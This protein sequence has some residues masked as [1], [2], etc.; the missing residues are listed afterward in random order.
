MRRRLLGA[1]ILCLLVL[2]LAAG[3]AAGE[4]RGE[5]ENLLV[6]PSFEEIGTNGLPVGWSVDCWIYDTGVTYQEVVEEGTDGGNCV[7]IENVVSNDARFVQ[8]VAVEPGT[9]YL[10]YGRVKA[11]GCDAERIGANLS[12]TDSYTEFPYLLDTGGEWRELACYFRTDENRR[13]VTV[14]ARLGGYSSDTTGCAWFDDLSLTRIEEGEIP[15]GAVLLQLTPFTVAPAAEEIDPVD[16]FTG[17]GTGTV[18]LCAVLAAVILYLGFSRTRPEQRRIR[19]AVILLAAGLMRVLLAVSTVGYETD[20]NCFFAWARTVAATGPA[21]FYEA[22][23]FCD[24]P[25]G[26]MLLLYPVGLL[27]NL[28]GASDVHSALT[29]LILKSIPIAADLAAVWLL[30]RLGGRK[31]RMPAIYALLPAVWIDSALW[32]QV[33]AVLALGLLAAFA[34]AD[35]RDWRAAIPVYVLTVLLKPQA[36]MAAPV[37]AVMLALSLREDP[38]SLRGALTGLGIAVA[39]GAAVVL[40]FAWGKPVTWLWNQYAQTLSSYPYATI[41]T[42]NFWY[43]LGLNWVSLEGTFL[44]V[45][46]GTWGMAATALA[47]L[48]SVLVLILRRGKGQAALCGAMLFAG[49][50]CFGVRMHERYLFPALALLGLAWLS[51]K[52]RRILAAQILMA[53][54]M[55]ANCLWVLEETHL[56][57]GVS[58]A[59]AV[60]AALNIGAFGLTVWAALDPKTKGGPEREETISGPPRHVMP[61]SMH[62]FG[63][64]PARMER[65]DWIAMLSLTFVYALIAFIG[66]GSTV[67]PQTD[68]TSTGAAETVEFDLGEEREFQ[69]LYYGGITSQGFAVQTSVDGENWSEA[70]EAQMSEGLCFRWLYLTQAYYDAYG[71]PYSWAQDPMTLYGRWVRLVPDGP[72]LTLFEVVFRTPEG[73][74]IEGVAASSSGAREANAS[75]PSRLTDESATMPDKPSYY[76]GTYFDEIYHART[77]YEHANGLHAYEWTHPPLG[78]IF[79][80]LGI[81]IF[82]MTAFGWRFFGTLAG[83]AMVP[84]M[85]LLGKLL[86]RRRR[87]AFLAAF[88][89]AFDMMHLTQTRIATIDSYAVL[90]IMLM[91]LCMLRWLQMD[92]L[93]DRWRTLI[94][95]G[96]SGLFMGL[97]CASK[98]ICFY[99]AAGLAVLF[100]FGMARY[101]LRW[102]EGNRRGDASAAEFPK[103]AAGT[104]LFCVG[105]F[106]VLPALIYYFS[107]IPHFAADG[108]LTWSRFWQTQQSIFSYHTGLVDDHAFKSPWYE[109]P[110]CLKP[111]YYYDGRSYAPEGWT[112]TIM[113]MGN[114]AVWWVG[115]AAVVW[116]AVRLIAGFVRREKNRDA[117]PLLLFIAL[118]AQFVPWMLVPRSTFIYH[119]FASLPFVMLLTVYAFRELKI[120]PLAERIYMGVTVLLF[121]GFYPFA[122]GTEFPRAWADAM[123]W[124]RFLYLPGWKYRGWLYY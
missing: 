30:W 120:P 47:V 25:P 72:G 33:D 94:P 118:A 28:T 69:I 60:I 11:E 91:T 93:R 31:L 80:M 34:L 37:G 62:F 15:E 53:V 92:L 9:C 111:M 44:G 90:F 74:A 35:R 68:W 99:A 24:Y 49:V 121:I 81:R 14:A 41:N 76:N 13:T 108:G 78:K 8:E 96:L 73:E 82:G 55:A 23:G 71:E 54:T 22:A 122:T 19:I 10:L 45:S 26:Y 65:K 105:V 70:Y 39:A 114:P 50:Y 85:Y 117:V 106:I 112:A 7:M 107:Y 103:L 124:L 12:V 116:S 46:Y 36:L 109:W 56:P 119:Y 110:L 102:R 21:R 40:P 63:R 83:V 61:G 3:E 113:C 52:D 32:G 5:A 79:I 84:V 101:F 97:G 67:A 48:L 20:V 2:G 29:L 64:Q 27:L 100:F 98:W 18:L 6:N 42:A 17:P 4:E 51:R 95:L 86:F 58:A 89:M 88:L 38:R 77:G 123:N 57:L 43:L 75:D 1:L 115:F 59:A 66:V 87:W 104:L 16:R